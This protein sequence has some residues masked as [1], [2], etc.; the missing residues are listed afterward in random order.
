MLKKTLKRSRFF[1]T[2]CS[3]HIP[4]FIKHIRF[5][6]HI[7]SLTDSVLYSTNSSISLYQLKLL[8]LYRESLLNLSLNPCLPKELDA[9]SVI[10][11]SCK[12]SRLLDSFRNTW[13]N[14]KL[15]MKSLHES[16]SL[17]RQFNKS[18]II[19]EM[20]GYTKYCSVVLLKR[21]ACFQL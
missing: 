10:P 15:A 13:E 7:I 21:R 16:L 18:L 1:N 9:L 17:T 6:R 12:L 14:K 19:T 11:K 20:Q 2:A 5:I 8:N 4:F 3:K